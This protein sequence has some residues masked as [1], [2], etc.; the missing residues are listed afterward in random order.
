[1]KYKL[2]RMGY[3]IKRYGILKT[4]KKI[5]VKILKLENRNQ[6]SEQELY[7]NWI[8]QNEPNESELELQKKEKFEKEPKISVVVPMYM[9]L[10]H[11]SQHTRLSHIE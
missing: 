10:I 3:Y 8:L 6:V 5:I 7:Q 9:S 4:I 11:N 1:M 2:Q